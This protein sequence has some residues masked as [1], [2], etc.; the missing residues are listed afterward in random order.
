[1][2]MSEFTAKIKINPK[3]IQFIKKY[4]LSSELLTPLIESY[5]KPKDVSLSDFHPSKKVIRLRVFGND[6]GVIDELNTFLKDGSYTHDRIR[7]FKGPIE[8]C[9]EFLS[10]KGME[11]WVQVKL[12]STEYRVKLA[13]GSV[14]NA[15]V[16]EI[17]GKKNLVKIEAKSESQVNS[18][19]QM[20]G[21]SQ[22]GLI[23]KNRAELL[24]EELGLD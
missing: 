22:G 2:I 10:E 7:L 14:L 16:E 13:D 5:W 21:I 20:L 3:V 8:K 24:A 17:N 11:R 18:I 19:K 1:M 15:L 6:S 9:K 23:L 12:Q 4:S